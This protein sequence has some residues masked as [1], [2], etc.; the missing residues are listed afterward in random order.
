[1]LRIAIVIGST[2]P[3]R[4]GTAVGT[5]VMTAHAHAST[6]H[7]SSW[8]QRISV[9]PLLDEPKPVM[10]GQ[11]IERNLG[12]TE[13]VEIPNRG[14]TLTFDSGWQGVAHMVLTLVKRVV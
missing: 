3:A 2:R 1:M 13:I 8:T 11:Y 5:C 12:V 6:L 9:V 7:P 10:S 14:H 4:I